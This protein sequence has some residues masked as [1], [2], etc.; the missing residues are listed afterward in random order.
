TR[1]VRRAA[2]ALVRHVPRSGGAGAGDCGDRQTTFRSPQLWRSGE[3]TRRKRPQRAQKKNTKTQGNLRLSSLAPQ[4]PL[5][6]L[7]SSFA[8]FV[9]LWIGLFDGEIDPAERGGF[10]QAINHQ[11]SQFVRSRVEIFQRDASG[12]WKALQ[13]GGFRYGNFGE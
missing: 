2:G 13:I 8:P 4:I 1:F 11:K 10:G 12:V 6:F 5:C 9:V 7:C 3:V